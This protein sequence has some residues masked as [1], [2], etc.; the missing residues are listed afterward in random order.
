[1]EPLGSETVLHGTLPGG[2][3]LVAKLAG[4]APRDGTLPVALPAEALHVF[5]AEGGRRLDP[6]SGQCAGRE[7]PSVEKADARRSNH[8]GCDVQVHEIN[9]AF[10]PRGAMH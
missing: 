3:T 8:M 1:M 6:A 2:E 10:I 9:Q 5:V 7:R 4:P